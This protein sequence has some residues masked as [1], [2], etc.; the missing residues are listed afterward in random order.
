M[1]RARDPCTT[2]PTT[3]SSA[4]ALASS[5]LK[6]ELGMLLRH[7]GRIA[8]REARAAELVL[9]PACRLDETVVREVRERRRAD[10]LADLLDGLVGGDHLRG[11][12][13]VDAVEALSDHGW[14]G[15][16]HVDLC[17]ARIEEHPH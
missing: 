14:R 12:G 13:Q 10:V 4:L 11:I 5:V 7:R 16:A 15:N 8:P 3:L 1:S 2:T 6:A 9:R 17:R